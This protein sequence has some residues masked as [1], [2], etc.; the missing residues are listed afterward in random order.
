MPDTT[1]CGVSRPIWA[2]AFAAFAGVADQAW[3]E[4]ILEAIAESFGLLVEGDDAAFMSKVALA[5][6]PPRPKPNKR[7]PA[8]PSPG[9][10]NTDPSDGL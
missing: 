9:K 1:D 4:T 10:D 3:L 5:V 2:R 6:N 8:E 7:P